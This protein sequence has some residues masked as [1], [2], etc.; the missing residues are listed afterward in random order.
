MSRAAFT[1]AHV[2]RRVVYWTGLKGDP[3]HRGVIVAVDADGCAWVTFDF[4]DG[5]ML[6]ISN[7]TLEEKK[8]D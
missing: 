2:G 3:R 1:E 7:L 5:P 6:V 8:T 4:A